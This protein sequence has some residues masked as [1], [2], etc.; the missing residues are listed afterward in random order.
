MATLARYCP[1]KPWPRQQTFAD[2]TCTEALYGGAAGPGKTDA[3]L[4]AALMY[5]DVPGYAALILRRDFRR[6][7]MPGSI[8]DRARQWLY[9][10]DAKWNGSD[11]NF[12][13]P[14]GSVLQ[15]GYI[16]HPDDRF[17]YQSSEFQYIAWEEMTEFKLQND[18]SNPY[19]FMFSRLRQTHDI[20]VPL[21]VRAATNP[22]NIGHMWVKNHFLPPEAI[23]AL[24]AGDHRVFYM[25]G[26]DG[27]NTKAF[28]P[29]LI[30]DNPSLDAAD[31]ERKLGH[32]PAVTR[33][34]LLLGDWSVTEGSLIDSGQIRRYTMQGEML[35]PLDVEG[36]IIAAAVK[37]C[38]TG[39]R[40]AT[41]DTAGTEK[42][43]ADQKKGKRSSWSVMAVWDVIRIG[44]QPWLFLRHIWRQQV[45]WL[46]LKASVLKTFN[47]WQ[48]R[49]VI[50]EKAHF[51]PALHDELGGKIRSELVS[52]HVSSDSG[53]PGKVERAKEL[54]NIIAAGR[55]FL[56]EV[57]NQWLPQ[58][59]AELLA[60]TGDPDEP[61][62][63]ID[64]SSYAARHVAISAG[65]N[66]MENLFSG[67]F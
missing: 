6:L 23:A 27:P 58:Y 46:G 38:R 13:F 15:F 28:V 12:R 26:A 47:E 43:I 57:N 3:L 7:A 60:W 44:N 21:R 49:K 48:P 24:M 53:K 25:D 66:R 55:L 62:D 52:N 41:V 54:F 35:R 51:G 1:H 29:A 30:K 61:A 40:F 17:R 39:Y 45:G 50:I 67:V 5:V 22:G 19:E 9:N 20:G 37:D 65:T 64:V 4:M 14:S 59:E 32:L 56:P 33:A 36:K 34:R 18:E 63:Q 11:Y 8:M 10:T 42:Q 31:Y 16:D 2:L